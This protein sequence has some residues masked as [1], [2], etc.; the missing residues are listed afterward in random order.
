M[1]AQPPLHGVRVVEVGNF[2]AVP[3]CGMQL[4]DLGADVVKVENPR[5]GDLMRGTGPFL[6][7]E[8]SNFVRLNRNKRSVALDLKAD[9]GKTIFRRLADRA[10]V[11]IEN[12]RP[13]TM[14]SLGLGYASLS[15][16]RPALIYLAATG[17]GQEGPYAQMAGL[18]IIA[19]GMSGLM[20]ITGE[21]DAPPVKVGVPIADLTCALYATIAVLAALRARDRDG[22]GQFI[23]VSLL[24]SAVS[25]A[26]WEAGRYFATGTVASPTGSAHQ[27]IAPYQAVRASDGWFTFGA[28]SQAHWLRC[29][30]LFGLEGLDADERFHTNEARLAHRA[31][32]IAAIEAVTT[33]RPVEHWTRVLSNAGIPSGPIRR[34]DRVF[35]DPHLAQRGFFTDVPHETLG[36][37]RQIGSPM[38][39]SATPVR[40]ERAGPRLGVDTAAVLRELGVSDDDA[41]AL[42]HSGVAVPA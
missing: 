13:G 9:A 8:S 30:A 12:L 38:R 3:F 19:Q 39:M 18:D 29:C 37:V 4:A 10:D 6:D 23:D 2:M 14:D 26:V 17:F 40:I 22:R 7:G 11:V 25:F 24:E 28:N 42:A 16:E 5:G 21:P 20:S 32:L 36:L 1:S 15:A 31:E 41:A 33:T 35:N 27:A 34:F